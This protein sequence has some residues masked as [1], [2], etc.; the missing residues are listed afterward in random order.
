MVMSIR[1]CRRRSGGA[2]ARSKV[3]AG[4]M[5]KD[6]ENCFSVPCAI[7]IEAEGDR[8]Q[9]G[10]NAPTISAVTAAAKVVT[11]P[12]DPIKAP[13]VGCGCRTKWNRRLRA[14]DP[15]SV[16]VVGKWA[17]VCSSACET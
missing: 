3:D 17:G 6:G 4:K 5:A 14:D 7:F 10:F 11:A 9:H 2:A 12:H 8:G 16:A 13:T 15:T 1:R